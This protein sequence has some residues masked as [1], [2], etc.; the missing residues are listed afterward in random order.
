ME[1]PTVSA[2]TKMDLLRGND[3]PMPWEFF[4]EFSDLE[5]LIPFLEQTNISKNRDEED[6]DNIED[7]ERHNAV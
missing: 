2:W 7:D 1:E 6:Y 3:P 4:M 5:R